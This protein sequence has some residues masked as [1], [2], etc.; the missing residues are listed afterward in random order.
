MRYLTCKECGNEL[1]EYASGLS[2]EKCRG[3]LILPKSGKLEAH[4]LPRCSAKTSPG[5][6][7]LFARGAT[8]Y[9]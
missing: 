2:C 5:Q 1:T 4:R 9:R 7:D 6:I 3:K 8:E